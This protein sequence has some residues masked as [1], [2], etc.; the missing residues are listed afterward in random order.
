MPP[1]RVAAL[2]LIG[3]R[4][5]LGGR[6][7]QGAGVSSGKMVSRAHRAVLMGQSG[8]Y[9][10]GRASHPWQAGAKTL[11]GRCADRLDCLCCHEDM[12]LP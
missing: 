11:L 12:G 2:L 8:R 6:L 9:R 3:A 10:D 7:K 1:R 4:A 5:A